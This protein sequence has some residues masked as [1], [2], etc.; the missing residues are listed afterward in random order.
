VTPSGRRPK[1]GLFHFDA[2]IGDTHVAI[3][4]DNCSRINLISL[5]V[6]EKLQLQT[7]THHW[8]YMLT[9]NDHL[10]SIAKT[11]LVPITIYGH[12]INIECDVIPR[13]LNFCHLML[14]KRWCDSFKVVFGGVH[15]D[16]TIFWNGKKHV[17]ISYIH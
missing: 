15:L 2:D 1:S 4:I 5:E 8:P 13:T 14:G 16:P 11:A 7:Y 6:V 17:V 9:T 12:T 10:V 3:T